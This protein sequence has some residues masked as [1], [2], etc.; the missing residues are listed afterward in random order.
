MPGVTASCFVCTAAMMD[1]REKNS[2]ISQRSWFLEITA[3]M[4]WALVS[5]SRQE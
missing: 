2:R 1:V 4:R 3:G 5:E